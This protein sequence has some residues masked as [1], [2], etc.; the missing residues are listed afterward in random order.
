VKNSF[1]IIKELNLKHVGKDYLNWFRDYEIKKFILKKNYKNLDEL[2]RYVDQV[3]KNKNQLLFGIF[4]KKNNKH[5]GNIKFNISTRKKNYATLGILIGDKNS[6]NKGYAYD[7]IKLSTEYIDKKYRINKFILGVSKKNLIAI[8]AYKKNGFRIIKK[9]NTNFLMMLDLKLLNLNKFSLGTAQFGS[10]YGI[11]NKTGKIKLSEIKR[12]IECIENLGI[13]NIDTAIAYGEAEKILGKIGVKNF[14]ITSKIPYISSLEI[15]NIEKIIKRSLKN[16]RIKSLYS[17]LIHDSKNINKNFDKLVLILKKIKSKG[18]IKNLGVSISNFE[19][20]KKVL[21]NKNIDIIQVP[22]NMMDQRI[23]ERSL[24]NMIQKNNVKIHIR[25]IFLQGL[26]FKKYQEI[27]KMFSKNINYVKKFSKILK[28]KNIEK[29]RLFVNFVYLNKLSD[30]IILGVDNCR[31]LQK[32]AR[33]K[34]L[35]RINFPKIPL[36]FQKKNES[37]INPHNWQY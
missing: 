5:I 8:N 6:R 3:K 36:N 4:L 18:L 2:K 11:N 7:I 12:I 14:K 21:K 29:L 27:K 13:S 23:N 10:N 15:K 25:S 26:L 17:L 28:L 37:L 19:D 20:L 1:L 30:Q 24:I 35:E 32:I 34:R 9:T 16:L 33:I 31:Q 22:F